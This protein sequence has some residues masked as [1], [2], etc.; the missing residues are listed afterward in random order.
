MISGYWR[1]LAI[2]VTRTTAPPE[3]SAEQQTAFMTKAMDLAPKYRT[4]LLINVQS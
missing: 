2:A 4:E 1:I 3:L